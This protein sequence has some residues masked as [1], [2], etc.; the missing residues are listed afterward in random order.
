M[1]VFYCVSECEMKAHMKAQ[2]MHDSLFLVNATVLLTHQIDAA[3]WHEWRLF[4]LPGGIGLF[5][6]LNLPIVFAV[7]YGAYALGAERKSGT[8]LSW[9]LVAGGLFAVGFHLFHILRGDEAFNVFV[10]LGLLFLTFVFSL[11][12]GLSL[13]A[14]RHQRQVPRLL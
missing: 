2:Q 3:Y 4:S 7:L 14:L 10:S 11:I 6:I 8:S 5:L 12:Q 13:L 1:L 9:V